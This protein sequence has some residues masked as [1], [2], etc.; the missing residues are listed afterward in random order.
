MS[1]RLHPRAS[2]PSLSRRCS[3]VN[4]D[5]LQPVLERPG[6]PP[7]PGLVFDAG[8]AAEGVELLRI[9]VMRLSH[10]GIM[11]MTRFLV[12]WRAT[13]WLNTSGSGWKS[14]HT[15]WKRRMV[16]PARPPRRRVPAARSGRRRCHPPLANPAASPCPA[17]MAT[18]QTCQFIAKFAWAVGE[19]LR[20]LSCGDNGNLKQARLTLAGHRVA[21]SPD[22]PSDNDVVLSGLATVT[23]A[24]SDFHSRWLGPLC[25][26][27]GLPVSDSDFL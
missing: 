26:C 21:G 5:R 2:A 1:D 23:A 10:D 16:L 22:R 3:T 19:T 9:A 11:M 13:R 8:Q 20:L 27:L 17:L 12:L 7:A 14:A 25:P 15:G 18:S 24:H 4:L 6:A